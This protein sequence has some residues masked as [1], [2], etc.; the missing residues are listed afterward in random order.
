MSQQSTTK[1]S[2]GFFSKGFSLVEVIVASAIISASLVA[3]IAVSQKSI[4]AS[5]RALDTYIAGTLLE[6]GAEAVRIV[7]DNDWSTISG[8]SSAVTYYPKFSSGSWTLTTTAADGTVGIYTR[9][10]T[11]AA[12]AR[13]SND[14]IVSSGGTTDSGTRLATVTVA[15]PEG[16]TT[17]TKTLSFYLLDIFS[18]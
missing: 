8:L 1:Q 12:V 3:I 18:S 2:H 11:L 5:H 16:S 7:R 15:W 4:V 9:S 6:E 13:D 17:V 14:D 10:V